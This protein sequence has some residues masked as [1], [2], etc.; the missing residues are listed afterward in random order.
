MTEVARDRTFP[1][2]LVVL[3]GVAATVISVAGLRGAAEIITPV[4]LAL[5]LV[6]AVHPVLESARAHGAPRW[7]AVT[8][9]LLVLYAVLLG[10]VVTLAISV[11]R[12][13][14]LLP[15]YADEIQGLL[16]DVRSFLGSLGI[17]RDEVA[18]AFAGIDQ[19]SVLGFVS[20]LVTALLHA[21][22][23]LLFVLVTASFMGMD[24]SGLPERLRSVPGTSPTLGPALA[25]FVQKTRSYLLVSTVFGLIVAAID[26]VAL[27]LLGIPLPILWGLLSWI[28]N[29][30]PNIGFLVGLV[31]PALLALLVDGP[32]SAVLVVAI[33]CVVNFV[34]QSVIQ[35]AVVGDAVGLSVT[36]TFLSLVAW[37]WILGPLGALLALPLSLLVKAVLLDAD[38][39]R[40]WA[41]TL[42]SS[43]PA[44]GRT[45]RR[46]RATDGKARQADEGHDPP[47]PRE[48]K[49][50]PTV[51]GGAA[52]KD[53]PPDV[54]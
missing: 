45:R 1:R 51:E 29:Y 16:D 31:P 53:P 47:T 27:L 26:T 20:G 50:A 22:G 30:I 10:L 46:G 4:F 24:A 18:S 34:I 32:R 5:I 8:L 19:G 41:L 48:R 11:A 9:A 15:Q 36:V 28:T 6:I 7:L 37:T 25:G 21:V 2:W 13:A 14:A 12:L 40:Q 38:P 39:S 44:T 17:E 52:A 43:P 35:P 42:V 3:L 49:L 23:N 33:Y 54:P